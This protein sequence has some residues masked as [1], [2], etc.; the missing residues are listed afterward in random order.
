MA[1]TI[2]QTPRG[3]RNNNPLNLRISKSS[4]QGKVSINTDGA[5]E[6]FISMPWGIRAG[7]INMRTLIRRAAPCT[8]ANLIA[9]WAPASDGNNVRAYQRQVAVRSGISLGTVL[10]PSDLDTLALIASA[11]AYVECGQEVEWQNFEDA[12]KLIRG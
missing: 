9:M 8:L 12:L 3:I 7:I 10:S 5:F 2:T 4:W 6:Q 11:M 1:K